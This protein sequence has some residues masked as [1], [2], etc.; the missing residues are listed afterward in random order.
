[1][2]KDHCTNGSTHQANGE[3]V[4]VPVFVQ[5]DS[6][7]ECLMGTNASIPLG[8]KF[9]DGKGKPLRTNP[10]PLPTEP[11]I[12][13]VSLIKATTIPSRKSRFLKTKVTGEQCPGGQFL[14]ASKNTELQ[15]LGIYFGNHA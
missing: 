5:P 2:V 14:F 1:M 4:V 12:V 6:A 11:G 13:R 8:F 3:T 7:Q 9:T 15:S 10:E